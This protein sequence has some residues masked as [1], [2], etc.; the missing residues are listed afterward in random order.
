V[1]PHNK[2][3]AAND[4][5]RSGRGRL[6]GELIRNLMK[7][8]MQPPALPDG[9]LSRPELDQRIRNLLAPGHTLFVE[10]PCGYGKSHSL[11]SALS[12]HPDDSLSVRWLSLT[13]QEN[14]PDRF[15]TL[16]TLALDGPDLQGDAQ[17]GSDTPVDILAML[18]AGYAASPRHDWRILVV[19]NLHYLTN[20]ATRELLWHL[21]RD[22]PR[23][24]TLV[25]ASRTCLPFATHGLELEGRFHRVG[26]EL[27]EFTRAETFSF[28]RPLLEE[29]LLTSVAVDTLYELTEGWITPLLL[30]RRELRQDPG[31]QKPIQES[32]SVEGF[33]R[34]S[35][36]ASLSEDQLH[37][38]RAIA[39]LELCSDELFQA[40]G[41]TAEG[42]AGI[43][44]S[45]FVGLGLPLRPMPGRGRWY[46]LN[47][48]LQDWLRSHRMSGYEARVLR[49]SEWFCRRRQFPEALRYALL[50]GDDE[51]VIRIA[52]ESS[53]ALLLGQDTASLLQLRRSLPEELLQRSPRLRI[54]YGWVHAIGGQFAQARTLIQGLS[55]EDRKA[56]ASRIAA[57]QAFIV[58]GEGKV[59]EALELAEQALA[60]GELS[61]QG[62]LVTQ[63]VRSSALCAAGRFQEARDANRAASRLA[64]EAGDSGSEALAVYAHARIEL[65]KGA[66]RHAEQLLRTGLDTAM[67]ELVRPARVGET[68]LQLNLVLLLWHQGRYG[69][70]DRLLA[71]CTR[72]AEQ[73]RDLG[74][75]LAMAI[76]VLMC[77]V[78]GRL[79]D[80]FIW[81]GRA[82]RT[83]HAWQVDEAL[84]VPVLEA[85]KASCW[86]ALGQTDSAAQAMQRLQP[87]RRARC[88][89]ELFP[90]MPGLL[91]CLQAR[92][93]LANGDLVQA[94]ETLT[95]I[96]NGYDGALPWGVELHVRLLEAVLCYREKGGNRPRRLLAELVA[97]AAPEHYIS[98]FAELRCELQELMEKSLIQAPEGP[99]RDELAR[100][101]GISLAAGR[102]EAL[103]EPISEREQGV[104]ELIAQGLSN[105]D[106]ADR[107]HISLHT[108]KTH[109]RRINAKLGVRSRTQAIVRAREL[110]LL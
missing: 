29:N 79:E 12:D 82:E 1:K 38:L 72:Q 88:V 73:A 33:F 107:L 78:E 9:A 35:V 27:L 43:P 22:L 24:L 8:R 51:A 62:Q 69:E 108:V 5:F 14:D 68:R 77:R 37:S 104:L 105:Q 58:R 49:A 57:L 110:G 23:E 63:L 32:P 7:Q 56:H 67:Q 48:L 96:R 47:P 102:G 6:Q 89:P 95:A 97:E 53:E 46:R 13:P 106:I 41:V 66:L 36:T 20:P 19:D 50:A 18:L 17:Q 34:N 52:S 16:L 74:L 26:P 70:A 45:G 85:L 103:A 60:D 83:M 42:G 3:Q 55:E 65:G 87:Y 44:P 86:L 91:D 71:M 54:V 2:S 84:F 76:R 30:Y 4:E 28:F 10:A 40:L 15:L 100:L 81:I 92:L 90:M 61:T 59:E 39:E 64:R 11:A 101:F 21:V 98:P 109:A 99:F 75:L 80:S 31:R 93:E 94:R 25:L